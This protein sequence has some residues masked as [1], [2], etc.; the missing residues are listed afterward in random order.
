A[1]ARDS[2]ADD[3][4]EGEDAPPMHVHP[5]EPRPEELI[6]RATHVEAP[7]R[8]WMDEPAEQPA[9]EEAPELADSVDGEEAEEEQV[10]GVA[11][12]DP[13]ELTPQGRLRG[14]VTDDPDFVW[15]RPDASKLLTRS[16]IEQTRPD[17]AG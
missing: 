1:R 7:S 9:A 12:A 10:A 3:F 13:A 2:R 11:H 17:T 16:T 15:E 14:A 5:P 8:D 4:P 6:V